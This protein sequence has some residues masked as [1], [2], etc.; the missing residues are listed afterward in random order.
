MAY[1][2]NHSLLYINAVLIILSLQI[3]QIFPDWNSHFYF[4]AFLSIGLNMLNQVIRKLEKR[5]KLFVICNFKHDNIMLTFPK[6]LSWFLANF[7][8]ASLLESFKLIVH[9]LLA[10]LSF[11]IET[12]VCRSLIT[13]LFAV[14][15]IIARR[16]VIAL[17]YFLLKLLILWLASLI[18]SLNFIKNFKS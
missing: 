13:L 7:N 6:V 15:K 1:S 12:L 14:L 9:Y 5:T 4:T 8:I 16:Q 2:N 11:K 17:I 10:F 18:F 3:S